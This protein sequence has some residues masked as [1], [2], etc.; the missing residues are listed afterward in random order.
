MQ[1]NIQFNANLPVVVTKKERWFLA[2]CPILDIHSQ[3][4]SEGKAKDN[5]GEALS[6]FFISCFE[7]GVLDEVLKGCGF[8]AAMPI[9]KENRPL[10]THE[11][12]ISV[13]IPFLVDQNSEN[14][15]HA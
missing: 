9:P 8:K 12:Y 13:P 11:D 2:T 4:E 7:R 14:G 1:I 3:G 5:L 6:L 10:V 15:C